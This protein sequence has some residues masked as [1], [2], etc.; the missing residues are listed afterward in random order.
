MKQPYYDIL[1]LTE[2]EPLWHDEHGVP[3]FAPFAPELVSDIYAEEVALLD[4]QCQ[5]CGRHMQCA[6][7][8]SQLSAIADRQDPEK[9][10]LARRL[11]SGMADYGDPPCWH[12]GESQ[13]SGSTMTAIEYRVLQFWR[14]DKTT[15]WVRVTE[16]EIDLDAC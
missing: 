2:K 9:A 10:T 6:V 13:C 15:N 8:W 7:S 4:L 14:R 12:K 11:R 3:R 5:S 1:E 16:L